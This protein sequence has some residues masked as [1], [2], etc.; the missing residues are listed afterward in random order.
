MYELDLQGIILNVKNDADNFGADL[1]GKSMVAWVSSALKDDCKIVEYIDGAPVT[2]AIRP[3]LSKVRPYTLV[4]Y[5][6]TP[7]VSR[8]TVIA[9]FE[10]IKASN[11]NLVVL[12]RG[13]IAK[14]EF[15][16]GAD[17][18]VKYDIEDETGEFFR[19]TDNVTL[20]EA[21]KRLKLRINSY[22]A[23]NGVF[24]R[25]LDSVFIDADVQIEPGAAIEPNNIIR[26][27]SII[28]AGA[29][30]L[31]N[32]YLENAIISAGATVDSSRIYK[33]FIGSNTTVGP[34]AYIRPD[35]IIG[36]NCR[37]GDFV[38]LKNSAIADGCKISHLSY[39]GD[40]Q[41]GVECNIGCG[42]VFVNYDGVNKHKTVVGDYA[43]I[44]SNTNVIAPVVIE[45]HAFVAAGSTLTENVPENAL[46]IARAR[47]VNKTDW[48][49]NKYKRDKD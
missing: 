4:L 13:F 28:K 2:S 5:S 21:I 23:K 24:F 40:C 42:V 37:I 36:N 14:T 39:V 12:P 34:Y 17:E 16:I 30:L 6:D 49:G 31:P 1:F 8:A 33:S 44:G 35:C 22:H 41:M 43:F 47:Q 25:D 7:L 9:A 38:E 3:H 20:A 32:N 26:G 10:K 29:H 19:V 48:Q 46:A 18:L 15:L 11:Y 45:N 27:T